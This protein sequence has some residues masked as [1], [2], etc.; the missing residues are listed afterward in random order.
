V[1]RLSIAFCLLVATVLLAAGCG[2]GTDDRA[3]AQTHPGGIAEKQPFRF[4]SPTSVWNRELPADAPIDPRSASIMGAFDAEVE[5]EIAAKT[6]PWI[7]TTAYSVPIYRV[8]AGQPTVRVA[9]SA[10]SRGLAAAFRAVPLPPKA[11]PAKGSDGHLVVWQPAT[12]RLWEFWRLVEGPGG[13]S[14][15]WGGAMR[16]VRESPGFY[17]PS[18]YPGATRWWG[19]SAS[20]LSIAGGLITLEDLED[21]VINHALAFSVPNVRAG[22]FVPP[23]QR[24]DGSTRST[25]ALPEGAH[26]R[27]DPSLDLKALDLPRL[28]LMMAR[29]AQRY[30]IVIR[31]GS[32]NVA[33]FYAQDPTPT[34]TEPYAGPDGWLEG[35]YPS[36]LLAS[37]PWWHLELLRMKVRR[38]DPGDRAHEH[39]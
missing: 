2:G 21:G 16:D 17:G 14:A 5:R 15:S 35:K 19:A 36:Q 6:G 32:P 27:L 12:D 7:D 3:D 1:A 10:A 11:R 33:S 37:F 20:S 18:S 38:V 23:A 34:G 8:P 31:D 13:W 29:A 9:L 28:T 24:T 39:G 4:F 26:L 30:G 25:T 22:V